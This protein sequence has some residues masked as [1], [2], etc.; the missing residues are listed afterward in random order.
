MG[1]M[2]DLR[3]ELIH[4]CSIRDEKNFKTEKFGETQNPRE[5]YFFRN[6]FFR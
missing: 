2:V 1:R 4:H 5:N 6:E 3:P